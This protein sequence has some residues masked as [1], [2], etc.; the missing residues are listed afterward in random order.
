MSNC[1][2]HGTFP[3]FS[4][5]SSHLSICYCLQSLLASR[6]RGEG[7]LEDVPPRSALGAVRP[8]LTPEASSRTPTLAYSSGHRVYP[9][10]EVWVGRLSAIHFQGWFIRPVS[11]Y[12][13]NQG[14]AASGS[15]MSWSFARERPG[16]HS[17]WTRRQGVGFVVGY[18]KILD[19]I[20][21][22]SDAEAS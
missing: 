11:F 17:L 3:H 2:S 20:W 16:S 21:R 15:A 10:G 13:Q 6:R 22:R 9:D 12:L 18:P 1:C 5:Q 14:F 8:G 4:P 7:K 19:T